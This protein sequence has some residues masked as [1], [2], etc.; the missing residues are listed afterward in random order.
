[1]GEIRYENGIFGMIP[2]DE[3][4]DVGF[5]VT[6]P[7]DPI[8]GLFGDQKTD[9][10]V[11]QWQTIAT[12]YQ[13]PE[14]AQFHGFDTEAQ[15]AFRVPIDT[16]NIEKGL[17]KVKM[18][19]SER[20]RTLLRSGVRNDQMYDYIL[21]DGINLADRVVTR[22]KVAKNELMATGKI[23]IKE[24]NLDLTVDYG[25]PA[26]QTQFT[27]D[28]ATTSD[29]SA[30]IQDI[31]DA[32]TAQGVIIT[33]MMTSKK[34]ITKMRANAGLQRNINGNVG[35]G[36]LVRSQALKDYLSEE[37]GINTIITNDLTYRV[38]AGLG[39]NGRPVV[40]TK[41]YFPQ[42]KITFFATN[43]NGRMGIGLWGDPPEVDIE[44]F[45]AT[46]GTESSVSPYVYVSQY[47]EK[48][49]AVIWTKA[50]A[51]F[52]PVLYNPNSLFIATVTDSLATP[53][54][55]TKPSSTTVA[56]GGTRKIT[57]VTV[58][59]D[60]TITWASSNTSKATVSD[61]TVTGVA[62]GSAN[63]TASI[64]VDGTTY[65]DTTAVTVTA[66]LSR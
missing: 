49:P 10:I 60:A 9:N 56:V 18:N 14:M 57:A 39:S 55:T 47:S 29:L 52:I 62:T 23:T 5:N 59:A 3:W 58:P 26:A 48:D 1:M 64:T 13:I 2:Q 43:P 6:R 15:T 21:N 41:R 35:V 22:T 34:V 19:Q 65:T 61:G 31:I 27:I 42:D 20:M 44:K 8:D 17:I 36:A 32:A 66:L 46:V 50:S 30:Q 40:T 53:S 38:P 24:N 25:V 54:I 4:L 37:F 12:Q 7:N 16:H 63:I 11:A 51:L 33:G 45:G 28:I